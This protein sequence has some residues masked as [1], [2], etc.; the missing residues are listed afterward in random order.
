M[1]AQNALKD[2]LRDI[3]GPAARAHGY[4]GSAP[5][6][7]KL[8][9]GDC[10]VVNVQSSAWSS[11]DHV[12]FTVNLAFAPEPWLRWMVEE[13]GRAPRSMPEYHGLYREPLRPRDAAAG[14]DRWW[15]VVD[16]ASARSAVGEVVD[17]MNGSG[18]PVLE[19]MFSRETLASR[20][21]QGEL[22]KLGE[23]QSDH[24][25]D[26]VDALLLMDCGPSPE[27]ERLLARLT[28]TTRPDARPAAER[29]NA[30]VHLH[31]RRAVS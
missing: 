8:S 6:W 1:T 13:T 22:G 29:F 19:S 17:L 14:E 4:R 16:D 2:A 31:A 25:A 28:A 21:R 20:V 26:K 18:W 30:W 27:L 7:R 3:V 9:A 12:K 10:A 11:A 23:G 15:D 5:N 24:L